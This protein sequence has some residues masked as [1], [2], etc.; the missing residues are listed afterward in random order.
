MCLN[1]NPQRAAAQ[2]DSSAVSGSQSEVAEA[3]S[4]HLC[5]AKKKQ[6]QLYTLSEETLTHDKDFNVKDAPIAIAMEGDTIC[7]ATSTHYNI[8]NVSTGSHQEVA[9]YSPKASLPLIKLVQGCE[10]LVTGP[11]NLGIFVSGAGAATKPPIHLGEDVTS[12]SY[13]HP[14]VL[15]IN[16]DSIIV[17]SIFDRKPKQTISFSR[18]ACLDNFEGSVLLCT[19]D[20]IFTLH[21]V[22]WNKQVTDLLK[23]KKVSEALEIAKSAHKA[24]LT[25]QE[26]RDIIAQVK[27][28]AGFIQLTELN[29][30]EAGQHLEEGH[31]DTRAV[32]SL[33]SVVASKKYFVKDPFDTPTLESVCG[34]NPEMRKN[35]YQFLTNYLETNR[36]TVPDEERQA[37]DTAL[38]KLYAL[39]S[40]AAEDSDVL[41]AKLLEMIEAGDTVCDVQECT[42]FL[43]DKLGRHHYKALLYY[44]QGLHERGLDIWEKL[45]DGRLTDATHDDYASLMVDTLKRE[46]DVALVTRFAKCI[47][48]INQSSGVRVFIERSRPIDD[49]AVLSTLLDYPL[50]TM[51]FLEYLVLDRQTTEGAYHTQLANIY[52]EHVLESSKSGRTM[53]RDYRRKLQT[54]LRSSAFY[55]PEKLLELCTANN[56]HLERAILYER[57]DRYEE[58]LKVYVHDLGD[59]ASAKEFCHRISN[60]RLDHDLKCG[61]Y[62]SLLTI[63][64]SPPPDCDKAPLYLKEAVSL[65]NDDEAEFNVDEVLRMVPIDWQVTSLADFVI[66]GLRNAYHRLAMLH[67]RTALTKLEN[68]RTHQKRIQVQS[69]HFLVKENRYIYVYIYNLFM[70]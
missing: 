29:F 58:A 53:P 11:S 67:I 30:S 46:E 22:S 59:F 23:Q 61:L 25:P 52:L 56:L 31:A 47:L 18:G 64:M 26:K 55:R 54:F 7:Y 13:H 44:S 45:L 57:L 49:E 62:G 43:G 38:V 35:A 51:E 12:C 48:D 34:G 68:L 20:I 69:T 21:P 3:L 42:E 63:L 14:Y 32:I 15:C 40:Q 28:Q 19:Q 65:L 39:R 60:I 66:R 4:A 24:N 5:V 8:L 1:P 37:V 41:T 33:F 70:R 17:Y 10:F 9:A 27:Q 16:K 50:A 6:L 36:L 2:S